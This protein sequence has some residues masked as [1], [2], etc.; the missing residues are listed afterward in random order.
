MQAGVLR[1]IQWIW[2][3]VGAVWLMGAA[4]SKRAARH[5]AASSRLLHVA[6]MTTAFLLFYSAGRRS[7]P[8]AWRFVPDTDTVEWTGLALTA[9]GCVFAIWARI[10]LAGD[11]SASVTVKRDHRLVRQGPYGIVRHPIYSGFLLALA[12]T[13]LA[14][15]EWRAMAG[16]VLAFIGWHLKSRVEENFMA[17]QFGAEYAAYQREVKA[18]IPFVL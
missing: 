6:I 4:A 11:W 5:E 13:A 3:G 18:L 14:L 17:E 9:A 12:G 1:Y 10:M 16:L 15:G 7:G 2:I 8:F